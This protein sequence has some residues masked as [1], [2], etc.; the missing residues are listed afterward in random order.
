M[1]KIRKNIILMIS[2]LLIILI[3]L[4]LVFSK[5]NSNA[6]AKRKEAANS[7]SAENIVKEHFKWWNEKNINKLNDTMIKD[8]SNI[9]WQFENLDYVKLFILE[10][11]LKLKD[12]NK[13]PIPSG[14]NG[15]YYIVIKQDKNSSWLIDEMGQ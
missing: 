15:Q 6:A 5:V 3:I 4:I 12:N 10:Y 8:N 13:G 11:E 14:K 7:I 1:V 2:I 9:S